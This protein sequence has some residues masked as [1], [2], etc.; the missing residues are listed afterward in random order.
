MPGG[1]E[2]LAQFLVQGSPFASERHKRQAEIA[3]T[4]RVFVPV[5]GT[6]EE[7]QIPPGTIGI[8]VHGANNEPLADA[9]VR[10]TVL[11]ESI[12]QG[13][14]ET[15][16]LAT[17]NAEGNA[18]FTQQKTDSSYQYEVIVRQGGARYS[19]GQFRLK[20]THGQL[21]MMHV[22]PTTKSIDETFIATRALYVIE[23]R[24]DVFQIQVLFRFHNTNP[25]TWVPDH[26][27]LPLPAA[28]SAFRPGDATGDIRLLEQDS[29]VVITGS[30]TP[31]EHEFS[32][33]F[34]LPNEGESAARLDMPMAPNVV[35]AKLFAEAS[36]Q[37]TL[38]VIGLDAPTE[39][40]GKGGQ[41]ALLAARDFISSPEARPSQF[42]ARIGGLPSRGRGGAI[43]ASLIAGTLALFGIAFAVTR[44]GQASGAVADSDRR[45]A[46]Q[47]LL[48]EL[49]QV[50]KAFN[51]KQIGPKTRER[52]RQTLLDALARLDPSAAPAP[53]DASRA[54]PRPGRG[55]AA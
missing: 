28:A 17:T 55:S 23:P 15:E 34:Q 19:S 27:A 46:R 54:P 41:R 40:R 31:G 8:V 42:T 29:E 1:D 43:G 11:H 48:D 38:S 12:D 9:E 50:E 33:S 30:F 36:S 49:V 5:S 32:Y 7:P 4:G 51:A 6:R 37:M 35:D 3:R 47:L 13:N 52:T 10:M 44:H 14:S 24:D 26:F 25:M 39:T 22:Y 45:Q 20:S 2:A 18:G 16:L 53:P 21:V